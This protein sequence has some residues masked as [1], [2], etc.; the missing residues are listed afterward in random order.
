MT[1]AVAPETTATAPQERGWRWFVLALV[2]MVTVT[3][4]PGWPAALALVAGAVRL[5]FPIEQFAL[6]VLVAIA[7]C[8]VVG[9]WAG[10][11]LALALAWIGVAGWVVWKMPLA[12]Q[13][14]GAF[15]R[16]WALAMGAAFGLVCLAT[17]SRPFLGRA[18]AAVG[19]AGAVTIL[20]LAGRSDTT[21]GTFDGARRMLGAEYGRR[22][23]QSLSVWQERTESEVW[24]TFASRM[25]D[26]AERAER[27]AGTL[28]AVT[29]DGD[30]GPSGSLIVLAPALLGL[31]SLMALSLG[32][33]AYHRLSR[34]RIGPPLGALRDLRF[35][36]QLVWGLVVGTTLLLLPTLAEWR[37][38]GANLVCFFGTLYALRGAGVLMW[39]IPDR[40]A[41]VALLVLVILV[42]LLGPVLL[43]AV[44][45]AGTF[46]LGLGDTWRDFRAGAPRRQSSLP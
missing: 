10:G 14:Y 30:S 23:D 40:L 12:V 33:A 19:L 37:G 46:V 35:N 3:A 15:V 29:E 20:G 41:L 21:G 17:H 24:R 7:A 16:G 6:L 34:V 2:L 42:P 36:D 27:M 22:V 5:L 1:G 4:A 25:P 8:S 43:L 11:R 28:A 32:W 45:L 9:W 18:L 39:W 38:T 26:A 13:G 44:L 31:E